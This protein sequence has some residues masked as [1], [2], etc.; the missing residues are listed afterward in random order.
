[1]IKIFICLL[2]Y[3][4]NWIFQNLTCCIQHHVPPDDEK[5]NFLGIT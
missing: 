5:L 3:L 1:M 4:T 2:N